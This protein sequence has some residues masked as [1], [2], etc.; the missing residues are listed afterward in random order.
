MAQ[1]CLYFC[2]EGLRWKWGVTPRTLTVGPS[3]MSWVYNPRPD[4]LSY[5]VRDPVCTLQSVY[6]KTNTQQLKPLCTPRL[7]IFAQ[8]AREPAHN[9]ECSPLPYN[10]WTPLT[11]GQ[12]HVP[13]AVFAREKTD[14]ISETGCWMRARVPVWQIWRDQNLLLLL[15]IDPRFLGRGARTL[16]SLSYPVSHCNVKKC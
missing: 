10:I 6:T 8:A 16:H 11:C 15:G 12:L 13:A 4:R 2:H 3:R 1:A 5:A 9:E 14:C 7:V